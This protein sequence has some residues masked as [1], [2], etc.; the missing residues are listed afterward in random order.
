MLNWLYIAR[1]G[2]AEIVFGRKYDGPHDYHSLRLRYACHV[3]AYGCERRWR[4][5]GIVIQVIK[6]KASPKIDWRIYPVR[7]DHEPYWREENELRIRRG[8]VR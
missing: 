1:R 6:R 2:L 7:M 4:L 3:G 8:W 5:F